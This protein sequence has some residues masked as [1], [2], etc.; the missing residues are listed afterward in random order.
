MFPW[1]YPARILE[2][3]VHWVHRGDIWVLELVRV[4]G[5]LMASSSER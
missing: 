3:A 4:R 1:R 5:E 2:M